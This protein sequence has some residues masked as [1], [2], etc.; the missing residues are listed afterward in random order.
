MMVLCVVLLIV[1][2]GNSIIVDKK[3]IKEIKEDGIVIFYV[4]C[5][6]KIMLNIIDCV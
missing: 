5:Y 2:C 4:V 6:G 3:E 1:G